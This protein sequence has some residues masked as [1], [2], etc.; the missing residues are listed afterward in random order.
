MTC[1][2]KKK[3]VLTR[4]YVW[5]LWS[6]FEVFRKPLLACG[7]VSTGVLFFICFVVHYL[8]KDDEDFEAYDESLESMN[9]DDVANDPEWEPQ[10]DQ[11]V[12]SDCELGSHTKESLSRMW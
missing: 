8:L 12:D 9:D 7:I 5:C 1:L 10:S 11:P 6:V 3:R 2:G 4:R